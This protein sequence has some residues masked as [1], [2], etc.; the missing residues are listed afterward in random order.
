[1][2]HTRKLALILTAA[3]LSL[4][5][6]S[7]AVVAQES[8]KPITEKGLIAALTVGGLQSNELAEIVD[9]RGVDFALT[10]EVEQEL[11]DAGATSEVIEAVRTHYHP[12]EGTGST[13]TPAATLSPP[14]SPPTVP[15]AVPSTPGVFYRNGS[16]WVQLRSESATWHHEGLMHTLK[17]GTGGLVNAEVTGEVAGTHSPVTM[18]SPASFL[19]RTKK[20]AMLEDYLLVHLHE[21]HDNRNF[22]VAMGGKNSKDAVDFRAAKVADE[23]YEIDFTQGTGEYAFLIRSTVPRGNNNSRDG[24]VLSFR[25]TE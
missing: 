9:K 20:G 18:H 25:I 5:C 7:A 19:I 24:P 12:P 13:P 10:Q 15:S 17:K 4:L 6:A 21:K 1:M 23:V 16:N 11:R 3:G 8:T 14:A 2:V 22:K